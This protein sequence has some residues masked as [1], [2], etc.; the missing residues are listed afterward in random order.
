[1][2]EGCG[3]NMNKNKRGP[4]GRSFTYE[5]IGYIRNGWQDGIDDK[6]AGERGVRGYRK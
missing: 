3:L 1:M 5:P 4:A 2:T 6:T